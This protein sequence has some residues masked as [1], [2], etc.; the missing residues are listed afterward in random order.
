MGGKTTSQT[1]A[2]VG[3]ENW[4]WG[5]ETWEEVEEVG[6][7][8]E[9]EIAMVENWED[10]KLTRMIN[11]ESLSVEEVRG[12]GVKLCFI[13]RGPHLARF[14]GCGHRRADF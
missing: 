11:E 2:E 12:P 7:L 5:D 3:K 14:C 8:N 10:E 13:C 9:E 1:I 4:A 6:E